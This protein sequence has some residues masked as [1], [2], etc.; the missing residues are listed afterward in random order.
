M[1]VTHLTERSYLLL[2]QGT[3]PPEEAR[4]LARH[5]EEACESCEEFL[6][7]RP[8]A[9]AVD[10][11]ADR[12][13][14][15]LSPV[16]ARGNDLEF[17]R[18]EKRL[19]E[20]AGPPR[21]RARAFVPAA[22]AAT[23]LAAGVAGLVVSRSGPER[24]AWDGVKGAQPAAPPVR[25]RFA[26]VKPGAQAPAVEKGVSGQVV[27]PAAG[28]QFEVESGRPAHAALVRVSG[29]GA[30]EVFWRAK[31]GPGPAPVTR[32]G[33]LAAYSLEDLRGVQRFVLVASDEPLGP[34]RVAQL[35]A[36]VAPTGVVPDASALGG[37]SLDVIEV[38]VR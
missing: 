23:V 21:R 3:L 17:A 20:S 35:A 28:L 13:L 7:S 12:A 24:P 22:L 36:A 8:A 37:V 6:A 1:G 2:L 15:A 25:L 11:L 14:G 16:G 29:S 38:V 10:G 18:I 31:L 19:R 32:D 9:D 26:V 4:A 5:L 30:P 34:E 33:S 27:E